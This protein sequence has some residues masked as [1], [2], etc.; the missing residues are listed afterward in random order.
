MEVS[1][2]SEVCKHIG[3]SPH[4]TVTLFSFAV[5][6]TDFFY[7]ALIILKLTLRS[8]FHFSK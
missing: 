1:F 4:G 8:G 2:H 7:L 3:K 5:Q 6:K